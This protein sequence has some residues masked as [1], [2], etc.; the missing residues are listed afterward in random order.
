MVTMPNKKESQIALEIY[1]AKAKERNRTPPRGYLGMSEIGKPCSRAIWYSWRKFTPMPWDGRALLIFEMGDSVEKIMVKSLRRAG[2]EMKHAYPD[3]QMAFSDHGGFFA[4]HC[5]GLIKLHS[6]E[7]QP[8]GVF[9]CKS[10]NK[11]K[12][13]EFQAHGLEKANP[14]YWC[15]LQAYMGYSGHEYG[16]F[17]AM[18]KNDSQIYTEVVRFNSDAFVMIRAR[19]LSIIT[20]HKEDGRQ[21]IPDKAFDDEKS[22][23]CKWCDYRQHCWEPKDAIQEWQSCLSCHYLQIDPASGCV[24]KCIKHSV[25]LEDIRRACPDWSFIGRTP[26]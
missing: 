6:K 15:Q 1:E 21:N 23:E 11:N 16:L 7:G 20:T 22:V 13:E 26:F 4:G 12:F 17:A 10:A 18:G 14:A 8:W 2:Y 25:Q 9:E 19:A 3:E 24:P 5:D